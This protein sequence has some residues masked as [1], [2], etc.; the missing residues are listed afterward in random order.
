MHL[1]SHLSCLRVLSQLTYLASRKSS[2]YRSSRS[3][4]CGLGWFIVFRFTAFNCIEILLKKRIKHEQLSLYANSRSC[5]LATDNDDDEISIV[6]L[7]L[8]PVLFPVCYCRLQVETCLS[9]P[10]DKTMIV[11]FVHDPI[12]Y[13]TDI[14]CASCPLVY[15]IDN[16][17]CFALLTLP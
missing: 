8:Y 11:L 5:G 14:Q 2:W 7:K 15:P 6:S 13:C 16:T 4:Y 9:M 3:M 17:L 12:V 1:V 10:I